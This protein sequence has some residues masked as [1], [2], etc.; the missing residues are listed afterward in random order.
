MNEWKLRALTLLVAMLVPLV[1][2][3]I[4]LYILPTAYDGT[5]RIP[6]NEANPIAR[7]GRII[8]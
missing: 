7:L 3:E 8:A 2:L 4:F 6:V 5:R 1:C